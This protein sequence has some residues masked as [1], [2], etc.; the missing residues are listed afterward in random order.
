M[1]AYLPPLDRLLRLGETDY[2]Y[3]A[4]GITDDHVPEL[5]RM[6]TDPALHNASSKGDAVWAPMHAWRALADLGAESATVPLLSLLWRVD[7]QQDEYVAEELPEVFAAIGPSAIGPLTAYLAN[8]EH[9]RYARVGAAAGLRQIAVGY[10]EVR[11][12]CVKALAGP[13]EKAV[14]NDFT[15]NAFLVCDLA[16]LEAVEVLALVE[17]AFKARA[18]DESITGDWEHAKSYFDKATRP[19]AFDSAKTALDPAP[20]WVDEFSGPGVIDVA[21]TISPS[22]PRLVDLKAI[23][24]A[25]KQARSKAKKARKNKARNK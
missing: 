9:L 6:V 8:R 16:E 11:A 24:K 23:N 5:I 18:V 15:V 3:T 25:A 2:D 19:A 12:D 13:L 17:A 22:A 14:A 10:P 21:S 7:E 1:S 4:N 20:S